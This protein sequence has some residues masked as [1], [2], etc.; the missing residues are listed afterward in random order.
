MWSPLLSSHLYLKVT[1]TTCPVIENFKSVFYHGRRYQKHFIGSMT[2][3]TD[4]SQITSW[5]TLS[6]NFVSEEC[7]SCL[8]QHFVIHVCT[9]LL[10][11]SPECTC[12]WITIFFSFLKKILHK[13]CVLTFDIDGSLYTVIFWDQYNQMS[14]QITVVTYHVRTCITAVATFS[15]K[16]TYNHFL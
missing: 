7:F 9:K 6:H 8:Y 3:T 15:T 16:I 12:N 11:C 4:L 14:H 10:R 2:K 13:M 1:F 5:Q